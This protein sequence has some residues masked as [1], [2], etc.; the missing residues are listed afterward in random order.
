[1]AAREL[2]DL[3]RSPGAARPPRANEDLS[4]TSEGDKAAFASCSKKI[5]EGSAIE[6]KHCSKDGQLQARS[7]FGV[8]EKIEH[9]TGPLLEATFLCGKGKTP[10]QARQVKRGGDVLLHLCR[11]KG[12]EKQWSGSQKVLHCE[13]WRARSGDSLEQPWIPDVCKDQVREKEAAARAGKKQHKRRRSTAQE[14]EEDEEAEEGA[15]GEE[16]PEEEKPR[17]KDQ[18]VDPGED[19]R[20]AGSEL[21]QRVKK[22]LQAAG[23]TV[24][25]AEPKSGVKKATVEH[26]RQK[27]KEAREQLKGKTARKEEPERKEKQKGLTLLASLVSL[28][29]GGRRA[30]SR[31]AGSSNSSSECWPDQPSNRGEAD[32]EKEKEKD[33]KEEEPEKQLVFGRWQQL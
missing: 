20:A 6:V 8:I 1:M 13:A 12:C 23:H 18:V 19:T 22:R 5:K 26:L 29:K 2:A 16:E 32:Q 4:L 9:K 31:Q 17:E 14:P 7:L 3:R 10:E 24:A 27:L 33:E 11:K 21:M 25:Q 30:G 15:G 28:R